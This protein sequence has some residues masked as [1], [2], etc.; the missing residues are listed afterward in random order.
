MK[1]EFKGVS[2][3]TFP[4]IK[5]EVIYEQKRPNGDHYESSEI[6]VE[7]IASLEVLKR[8]DLTKGIEYFYYYYYERDLNIQSWPPVNP[9]FTAM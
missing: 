9:D 1:T 2:N 4:V 6:K 5:G 7:D 8:T 3:P